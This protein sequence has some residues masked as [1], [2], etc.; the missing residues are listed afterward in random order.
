MAFD[1]IRIAFFNKRGESSDRVSFRF[2]YVAR[3]D[4]DQFFPAGII[5]QRNTHH[6]IVVA[7]IAAL[8]SEQFELHAFE[9]LEGQILEQ[10]A[11]SSSEIMLDRIG[12]CEEIAT[13]VLKSVAKPY[14]FLPAID[15]DE[16][17][18]L[19]IAPEFLRFHAEI[20]N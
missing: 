17:A 10:R 9:L 15:C 5:R 16:P 4:N 19:Q 7:G 11:S 3:I 2:F 6:V 8:Y 14:Q 18:V 20:N 12:K 1:Y 13:S